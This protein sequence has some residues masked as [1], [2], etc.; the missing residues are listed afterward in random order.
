MSNTAFEFLG[1]NHVNG[2]LEDSALEPP[3]SFNKFYCFYSRPLY[4]VAELGI[5]DT[6]K[7]QF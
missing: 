5:K 7:M 1:T 3:I 6:Y 2:F 4:F